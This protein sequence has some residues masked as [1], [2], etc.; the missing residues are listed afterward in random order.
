MLT[1]LP[2]GTAEGGRLLRAS[3]Y[4]TPRLDTG[5]GDKQLGDFDLFPRWAELVGQL[6]ADGA[7]A[8]TFDGGPT[9]VAEADPDLPARAPEQSLW[10]LLLPTTT[11]VGTR[12]MIDL[13]DRRWRS[14]PVADVLSSVHD[15]YGSVAAESPDEFPSRTKVDRRLGRLGVMARYRG[16]LEGFLEG[17]FTKVGDQGG[18]VFDQSSV[19]GTMR[20]VAAY[21][22]ARRFYDR[23]GT[24]IGK[25]DPVPPRPEPRKLD[26]HDACTALADYPELLRRLGLVIDVRVPNDVPAHAK[27]RVAEVERVASAV[28]E[29]MRPWTHYVLRDR[30]FRAEEKDGGDHWEGMLHLQRERHVVTDLD[31]DGSA[32]KVFD[33]SATVNQLVAQATDMDP[34]GESLPALRNGGLTVAR[35]DRAAALAAH[36][37]EVHHREADA[38]SDTPADLW[39]DDLVR[40]YR[41]DVRDDRTGRWWSL[42][43]RVGEYLVD[44]Q[45]GVRL[46][47]EPDE[48]YVKIS[49]ATATP[50]NLPGSDDDLY[51]HE[52]VFGWDGW[53]LVAPRPGKVFPTYED[54]A[55]EPPASPKNPCALTTTFTPQDQ[56][57][58]VLRFGR[59][60]EVRARAVDLSGT[61][62]DLEDGDVPEDT[63][64]PSH[65]YRRWEPVPA[66]ALL[67]RRP[68]GEGES[69][70]RLVIRS[71]DDE[72]P[73]SYV[74]LARVKDLV[75]HEKVS[76]PDQL[77]RSYIATDH[78]HVLPPKTGLQQV[79]L[80]GGLDPTFGDRPQT[81]RDQYLKLAVR[82]AGTI[83]DLTGAQVV[84]HLATPTS[85][86][87]A[88]R[89]DSLKQGEHVVV[90]RPSIALPYLADVLAHDA[91]LSNVPGHAGVLRVP[92]GDFPDQE[93][94][95]IV[96][97]GGATLDNDWVPSDRTLT[98][99]LPPAEMVRIGLSCHL[100]PED[101]E[102]L[103]IWDLL[104]S[105]E[106]QKLHDLAVTGQH[107]MLTPKV[108]LVLVHAVELPIDPPVV[109][110]VDAQVKRGG[111]E[112]FAWF[113]GTVAAHAKSTG[114]LDLSATWKE[115]VDDVLLPEPTQLDGKAHVADLRIEAFEDSVQLGRD[116]AL[117]ASPPVH[118]VRHEFGD[119]K[120]RHVAYDALATTRFREYF[121]PEIT[122]RPDL[123]TKPGPITT[124]HVPS[125]RRPE[126]P[127]VLYM[128]PTF[129]WEQGPGLRR[130]RVG[131][132]V[133]VYLARP[134]FSSG[135]D[136]HLAVVVPDQAPPFRIQD[137]FDDVIVRDA[138]R[139]LGVR[140][141]TPKRLRSALEGAAADRA[142]TMP[143]VPME[144]IEA[145]LTIGSL[146]LT[147]DTSQHVTWW[148]TDP[149]WAS[150]RLPHGPRIQ[151]FT[152][153]DR[154]D[155]G[156]SLAEVPFGKVAVAA[157]QPTFDPERRLWY[158]DIDIEAGNAY[159]PFVRLSLA[160]YQP[161]SIPGAHLSRVVLGEWA[162]V[163]ADRTASVRRLRGGAMVTVEGVAT[164]NDAGER[165][166]DSV[167]NS[168]LVVAQVERVRGSADVGW[169]RVG[170][171]TVLHLAAQEGAVARWSGWVPLPEDSKTWRYR[172]AVEE[173]ELYETDA[174]QA[175]FWEMSAST[176]GSID[177]GMFGSF[178]IPG[179]AVTPI[180]SRLVYADHFPLVPGRGGGLTPSLGE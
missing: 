33:Y 32:T 132:G 15:L 30:T 10:D 133:R 39:A 97:A 124:V 110:V 77:D 126:P 6:L 7:I 167:D 86:P 70:R 78:R 29:G 154:W 23:P 58:P 35:R 71:T 118:R 95:R 55:T 34:Q 24:R 41:V 38:R 87:L 175:E 176:A 8:L 107:W 139:R 63:T 179:V 151:S 90:D 131:S 17:G 147:G 81:V 135:D 172:L 75:G 16:E 104:S 22:Q 14:F 121:P 128:V 180:R 96:L 64:S 109:E 12:K 20:E 155:T 129:R 51:L 47:V 1:V 178:D 56:S 82:E 68:F 2:H 130:T 173:H 170:E 108:E 74:R 163:T 67:P 165:M 177:L 134:W 93:P 44:R 94:F 111:G 91:A 46:Q 98:I 37:A 26:F 25:D 101:L 27:V 53:S 48:G 152:N 161:Y 50:E 83:F 57:L 21:G 122:D 85:L 148:G 125:S 168:H 72:T 4:V 80:H 52:A 43:K 119:T 145:D 65:T 61:S 102:L 28:P 40:G 127:E 157:Y 19:S 13:A 59:T 113:T 123:I 73:E 106:Q 62:W 144:A 159:F 79:E 45:G 114:R 69:T 88:N 146:T 150:E 112:T 153:A 136:E 84:N 156:L 164:F 158:V 140:G 60:Y 160:R 54:E 66:P 103:A 9:L 42:C 105:S 11:P 5:G 162:Q 49:N 31:V 137:R 143:V 116:D 92:F 166:G 149:I 76:G 171:Q 117:D 120:H 18:S 174:S 142:M 89:G 138:V 3:I 169:E 115:W 99:T 36:V 100:R 141:V